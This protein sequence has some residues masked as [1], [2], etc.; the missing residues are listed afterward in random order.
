MRASGRQVLGMRW[1]LGLAFAGVAGL[2]AVAI[3]TASHERAGD[4]ARRYAQELAVGN[5]VA[6][7]EDARRAATLD[8]LRVELALNAARR[9]LSL[10]AF[11]RSG[12]LLTPETSQ[13]VTWASVPGGGAALRTALGGDR[14]I[15]SPGTDPGSRFLVG[16][17]TGGGPA[18]AIVG[19][20][21]SRPELAGEVGVVERQFIRSALL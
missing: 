15:A 13:G 8:S 14:S 18:A 3:V 16:V 19:Y 20:S 11:D 6:A 10:F 4:V 7:S 1:W 12:R 9:R 21:H 5:T 17:R 2:T